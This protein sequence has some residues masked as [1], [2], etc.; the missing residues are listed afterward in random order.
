M[1]CSF[2]RKQRRNEALQGKRARHSHTCHQ[3]KAVR[4]VRGAFSGHVRGAG[5][6]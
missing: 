5:L 1:L 2:A 3:Y 4:A 6:V